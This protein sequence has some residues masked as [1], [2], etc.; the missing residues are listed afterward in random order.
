VCRKQDGQ[1]EAVYHYLALDEVMLAHVNEEVLELI[2]YELSKKFG[3]EDPLSVHRGRS[4]I[5][6]T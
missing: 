6:S 3:S 1:R 2:V 5:I 4:M